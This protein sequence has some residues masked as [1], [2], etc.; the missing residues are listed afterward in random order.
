MSTPHRGYVLDILLT[1]ACSIVEVIPDP[2]SVVSPL[3]HTL[4]QPRRDTPTNIAK[5]V[6][7]FEFSSWVAFPLVGLFV[8]LAIFLALIFVK[9]QVQGISRWL[10]ISWLM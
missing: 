3:S 5:P 7:P 2:D 10:N 6:R 8:A 4:S 9:A 1:K